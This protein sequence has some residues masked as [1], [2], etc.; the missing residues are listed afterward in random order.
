MKNNAVKCSCE[1]YDFYTIPV[2]VKAVLNRNK[3]HYISSQLEKLHPCFSDDCS[4]DTHLH[5]KKTGIKAD[6]VVMQKLKLAEY[7]SKNKR[8]YIEEQKAALLFR[9]R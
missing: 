3:K 6:V 4:F 8:L 9:G 5:L 1:D 2:P 7:K